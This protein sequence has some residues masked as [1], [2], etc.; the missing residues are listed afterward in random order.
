MGFKY[1]R[2]AAENFT[3]DFAGVVCQ[4]PEQ[5]PRWGHAERPTLECAPALYRQPNHPLKNYVVNK[6]RHIFS[7]TKN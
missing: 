2:V 4:F 5:I 3:T 7:K 6:I 1:F